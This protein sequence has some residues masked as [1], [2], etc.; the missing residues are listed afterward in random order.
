M[1][2]SSLTWVAYE[3][4]GNV[5]REDG[6]S[7]LDVQQAD[8]D[9]ERIELHNS[10]VCVFTVNIPT[11]KRPIFFRRKRLSLEESPSTVCAVCVGWQE[12]ESQE[13]LFIFLLPNGNIGISD[14]LWR[15]WDYLITE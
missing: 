10:D 3:R 12:N 13:G 9:I 7:F 14:D 15:D 5:W 11:D 2:N 8:V 6:G 4:N 1:T